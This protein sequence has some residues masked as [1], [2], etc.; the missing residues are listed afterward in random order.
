M[1]EVYEGTREAARV[2]EV[3]GRVLVHDI[4]VSKQEK[5]LLRVVKSV[6]AVMMYWK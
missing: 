4:R 5:L 1:S 2:C 3:L 6:D